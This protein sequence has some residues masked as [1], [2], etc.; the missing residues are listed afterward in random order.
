MQ[1]LQ[2]L[3]GQV[4]PATL[5]KVPGTSYAV[6]GDTVGR[7]PA[8]P[9]NAGTLITADCGRR[10]LPGPGTHDERGP[11]LIELGTS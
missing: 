10:R 1:A 5:G 8:T 3:R 11:H 9:W 4:L 7:H 6:A 2:T